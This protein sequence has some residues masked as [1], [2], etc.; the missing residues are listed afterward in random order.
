MKKLLINIGDF[1]Y[2]WNHKYDQ[3]KEPKRFLILLAF[4]FPFIVGMTCAPSPYDWIS[5]GSV[6]SCAWMRKL[7]LD[8]RKKKKEKGDSNEVR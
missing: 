3:V 2:K 7:Y 8:L 5:T 1:M 4:S 6:L